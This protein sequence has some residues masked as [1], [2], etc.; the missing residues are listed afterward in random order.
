MNL[1]FYKVFFNLSK[2]YTYLKCETFCNITVQG[3][4]NCNKNYLN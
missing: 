4:K 1:R 3:L 2:V